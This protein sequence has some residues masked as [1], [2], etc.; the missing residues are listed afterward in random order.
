MESWRQNLVLMIFV[1]FSLSG[2]Q[3]AYRVS[4]TLGG[5]ERTSNGQGSQCC[6]SKGNTA[7]MVQGIPVI[8]ECRVLYHLYINYVQLML[9]HFNS[10]K[11]WSVFWRIRFFF[12]V[13]EL[14][15]ELDLRLHLHEPRAARAEQDVHHVRAGET[16]VHT[17]SF[18]YKALPSFAPFLLFFLTL[19]SP[20]FPSFL[21]SF[22]PFSLP[23][24][25]SLS[26]PFFLPSFSLSFF[27]SLSFFFPPFL[28]SFLPSFSLFSLSTSSY[29]FHTFL[30]LLLTYTYFHFS[31]FPSQSSTLIKCFV[32]QL[33]SSCIVR[34]WSDTVRE[35]LR[36]W[37]SLKRVSR[38]WWRSTTKR[39]V[40]V[41]EIWM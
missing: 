33:S 10:T 18:H 12:Q 15:S 19:F 1:T 14:N 37:T 29:L 32:F 24:S 38:K 40:D 6:V 4:G 13:E 31:S 28:F 23:L 2:L 26:L 5:L 25:L 35:W 16:G 22:F 41:R 3:P 9:L 20:Y 21:P 36:H 11:L 8:C 34:E 7:G 17:H 30:P 39:R 27:L